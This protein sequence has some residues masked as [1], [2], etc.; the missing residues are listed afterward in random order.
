MSTGLKKELDEARKRRK[1]PTKVIAEECG[2]SESYLYKVISCKCKPGQDLISKLAKSLEISEEVANQK[3]LTEDDDRVALKVNKKTVFLS[4]KAILSKPSLALAAT[5][6]IATSSYFLVNYIF[7]SNEI[8]LSTTPKSKEPRIKGNT[9]Q[10]IAD[11]T[12]PDGTPVPTNT[13]FT[14]VWRLKNSGSV[15]WT[16]RF[17]ARVTEFSD[18]ICHSEKM[19][20]IKNTMPGE[21]VDIAVEFTSINLPGSCRTDWKMVDEYGVPF[22]PNKHGLYSIVNVKHD[23][24]LN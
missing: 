5:L 14:K 12:I 19:V 22:F 21:E 13:N 8:K 11:V 24:S 17:L 15:P 3:L 23:Y 18:L 16:N 7:I 20:P 9:T 2:I 6:T 10:F 4:R 1:I